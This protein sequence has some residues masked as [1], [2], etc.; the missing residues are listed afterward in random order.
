MNAHDVEDIYELT[1]LQQ[2]ML[3]HSLYDGDRDSYLAQRSFIVDGPLDADALELA[4]QQTVAAHTALRT[5]F[6][7]GELEKPLQVVH[8]AVTVILERDYWSDVDEKH[9][10]ERF[11]RLLADDRATGFD[12]GRVPLLRLH[13]VRLAPHRHGFVWTHH[14]L[15]MDGWSV[16][17]V[18][19]DVIRRYRALTAGEVAP[20]QA[21]PYRDYIAWLHQQDLA[22]AK[23]FW[24]SALEGSNGDDGADGRMA[25]LLPARP[26]AAAGPIG[27][28]VRPFPPTLN[29]DLR[30][31][32]GRHRV[33]VNTVLQGA[34]SLV[35]QRF[36]G[37][38]EVTFGFAS[39]GRPPHLRGVDRMV[40]TFINTLP[41]RV[42]V[43]DDADLGEWLRDLQERHLA[44]RRF[45]YSP[46]ADIKAWAGVPGQQRLFDSVVVFDNYPLDV[47][48]G[49]LSGR[50]TFRAVNAF[51]K[52]SEPLT[53]LI[54]PEPASVLQLI[55]QRE[56]MIPSAAADVMEHFLGALRALTALS[57]ADRIADIAVAMPRPDGGHGPSRRFP[58]AAATLPELVTRQAL[59]TPD[60]VALAEGEGEGEITYGELLARARRTAA[61]L[62]RTGAGPG[63][64]VGVCCERSPE[65]VVALLGTQLAGAAYL[66][67]DPSL[68]A[69]RLALMIAD[70]G[71]HTLLA[72]GPTRELAGRLNA[73][74]GLTGRVLMIGAPVPG[75]VEPQTLH[76]D[77][78]AY[79]IF[80]S[81]STGR[82]KGVVITH[83]AIVNRLLWMQD[84]FPIDGTD[85]VLQ[86]TPFGFD[87]SVWEMFWPLIR[88]ATMVLARPGGH[89]DSAHL[90]A[91]MAERRVTVAHFVPSMLQLF[92]E[93]QETVALPLLRTVVCSGESLS[94]SLVQRFGELLP[95][96]DLHNLYGPTEAA[97]DVTAWDCA[98]ATLP[99][100]VPIG[101]PVANTRTFVLDSRLI[102]AP[103][104]VP[105]ELY[106]GGVQLARGYLGRPGLTAER[107][108][109]HDLAGPGGRLYRTGDRVRTLP[110]GE[111]EFLGRL[112]YQVKI[113]GYRIEL[114]EIEHAL[115]EHPDVREAVV[116]GRASPHG[117]RLAAF[118]TTS[119]P[120]IADL[121][122]ALRN[123][124]RGKLPG[125]MVPATVTVLATLPLSTN[126]KLDRSALPADEPTAAH[127]GRQAAP[128]TPREEAVVA[129][130]AEVLGLPWV[131]VTAS[132]FDLGG[133]SFAAVRAVRRLD[134][135]T[136]G[137]IAAHPSARD[138]ADALDQPTERHLL[139]RLTP[140]C[141]ATHTLVGVPFG[142]GSAAGYMPLA[143]AL[144]PD[145]E[146]RAI[147]IPGHE[148]GDDSLL[149]PLEDVAQQCADAVANTVD[150]PLSVYGHCVGV[151][152]AVELVRLLEE[153]GRPV[154][155]LFL[156]ASYPVYE[157]GAL[158]AALRRGGGEESD[159]DQLRY[160]QSL[161]GFT[162]LA[163]DETVASVMR[164]LRH[165]A[166]GA[167][168]YFSHRWPRRR[169]VMPLATPITVVVGDDDPETPRAAHR[170][171]AWE[172]FS[173]RVELSTVA[174][175]RH[176][177]LQHQ[178]GRLAAIIERA[179][180]QAEL[181]PAAV[182]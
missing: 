104:G 180:A 164:A 165:D 133:D 156:G 113:H 68:P 117:Q 19:N 42:P 96:T 160:L 22:A 173:E 3:L 4:W 13:L 27:E 126:G 178:P 48:L 163:D 121:A 143:G 116:I 154:E 108:V 97:V 142:G 36:S 144:S 33:T 99:G 14:M 118:V 63:S 61:A 15:P 136:V 177:F 67:L 171:R 50:L 138:L 83:D 149:H 87:V 75:L 81:G 131:D 93:E 64:V 82:P 88:G 53:L 114:G 65:M 24:T 176:Y 92:C 43:P 158:R 6:H 62:R 150:G 40:G 69:D 98:E 181:G 137:M 29:A 110:G 85:R 147:S 119:A 109:A 159:E 17:I 115:T 157:L 102:P 135:A 94:N 169:F 168:R 174:G 151:A 130:Y 146:L 23:K 57:G 54:T 9:Q 51:E 140:P 16:P 32:A 25:T 162:G 80:T 128:T 95:R 124:L 2:G 79:V 37:A 21:A 145:V 7:W 120:D 70:A 30:A 139:I 8:R 112:D 55:Y 38:A 100:V 106:L 78:A 172:R 60:A 111:L 10:Q 44:V 18:L 73:G 89:Q 71:A 1:P 11:E 132:F 148:A 90:W 20:E 152:L 31:V 49:E 127:S 45:E 59:A 91:V 125:Y 103:V 170:Y 84:M 74:H 72:H 39:S 101:R 179:W 12:P 107:F 58:D 153:A 66:P 122:D 166:D 41:I 35:L 161:G 134:G 34:W 182:R 77:D 76:G 86:K 26:G 175:G 47:A 105:G 155:R 123:N 167:R 56:R 52:T 141:S 5:S 129:V 46:L 28:V